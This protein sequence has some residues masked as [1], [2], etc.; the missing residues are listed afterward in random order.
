MN[1]EWTRG[2]PMTVAR[3]DHGCAFLNGKIYVV[4]GYVKGKSSNTMEAFDIKPGGTWE[5]KASMNEIRR[6]FGVRIK[7]FLIIFI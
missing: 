4:G 3:T 6:E 5:T 1:N 7:Y 2:V